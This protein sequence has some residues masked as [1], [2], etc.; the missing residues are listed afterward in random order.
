VFLGHFGVGFGAKRA[1]KQASLGTLIFAAELLDLIWPIL[2]LTG[3]EHVAIK[4]G[5]MAASN[6]DLYF[7]PYSHS[8]EAALVWSL[9][10]GGVY[11]AVRRD[12][13]SASVVGL[14]VSSHWLL[15][16]ISHRPDLPLTFQDGSYLGLGAWNSLPL[17]VLLELGI[18]TF[19]FALY[20]RSTA[21]KDRIGRFGAWALAVILVAIYFVTQFG[22]PPPSEQAIGFTTL[23]LWITV[24]LGYWIDKH[25]KVKG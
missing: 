14:A 7:Y 13:R 4:P 16:F 17:T 22:P 20:I 6:L 12:L 3:I 18:F 15:D 23:L 2:L 11:Y 1:A 24:P 10:L 9:L 19:G 5:L 25:R 21:A 8:L